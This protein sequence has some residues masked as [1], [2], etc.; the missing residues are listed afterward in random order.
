M[1]RHGLE[2][3]LKL[4]A[5]WRNITKSLGDQQGLAKIYKLLME[6][7]EEDD[8]LLLKWVYKEHFAVG[9]DLVQNG[10]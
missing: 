9:S 5:L 8:P 4:V 2:D 3:Q 7:L 1:G 6:A 10:A